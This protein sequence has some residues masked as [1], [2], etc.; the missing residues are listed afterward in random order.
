MWKTCYSTA[1]D[2]NWYSN[3][4][5]CEDGTLKTCG[6][7]EA[8]TTAKINSLTIYCVNSSFSLKPA[9]LTSG[10]G[11]YNQSRGS[12]GGTYPRMAP[13]KEWGCCSNNEC[14]DVEIF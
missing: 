7:D 10:W 5:A 14:W 1:P 8:C 4:L 11:W 12:Y 9:W 13:N 2:K 6:D 3:T